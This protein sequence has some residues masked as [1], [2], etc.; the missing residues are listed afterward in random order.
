MPSRSNSSTSRI[1]AF[2]NAVRFDAEPTEVEKY[3]EP[4]QPPT[5]SMAATSYHRKNQ[6]H[7]DISGGLDSHVD[8]P[9]E[10]ILEEAAGPCL[11]A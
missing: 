7:V 3:C 4:V 1:T 6:L 5:V 9:F 10:R 11:V 2:T 8:A